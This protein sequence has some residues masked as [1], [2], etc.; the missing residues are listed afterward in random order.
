MSPLL[1]VKNITRAFGRLVA[2]DDLSFHV[3][4]GE[5]LGIVGANGAGKTTVFNLLMGE[6]YQ[7][8]GSIHYASKDI[9]R[10]KKYVRVNMGLSRTNQIPHP[11]AELTVFDNIRIGGIA[12]SLK[13]VFDRRFAFPEAE[14]IADRVGL[15]EDLDKLPGELSLAKT[16]KLELARAL[17]T[18]P[19]LLLVDE[20]FAGI[21]PV[22][23]EELSIL[24]REMNAKGI[25]IVMIDHNIRILMG[26]VERLIAI[27]FGQKIAEGLPGDVARDQ[28][29]IEAYLGTP[30]T[31][32][33]GARHATNVS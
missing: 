28:H 3:H 19:N 24:L 29:V 32:P 20:I 10:T 25:T 31:A 30:D 27:D 33:T 4:E 18:R 14:D 11:F 23:S 15:K 7:D 1:D 12:N 6:F 17:A 26:M 2:V 16:K 8:A 22:E 9:T 21:S 13:A 5:I